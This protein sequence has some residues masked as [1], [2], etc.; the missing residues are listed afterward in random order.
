VEW[1]SK[2]D[3]PKVRGEGLISFTVAGLNYPG[4]GLNPH[5]GKYSFLKIIVFSSTHYFKE[6]KTHIVTSLN[7]SSRRETNNLP[8]PL[9]KGD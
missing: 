2:Q 5:P 9:S 4:A 6:Y 3:S 8:I 1:G 7:P